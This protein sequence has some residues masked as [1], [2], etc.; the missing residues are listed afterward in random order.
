MCS[1][2]RSIRN[3]LV[4]LTPLVFILAGCEG[5][6]TPVSEDGGETNSSEIDAESGG[7]GDTSASPANNQPQAAPLA[8]GDYVYDANPAIQKEEKDWIQGFRAKLNKPIQAPPV[9]GLTGAQGYYAGENGQ[10]TG[11]DFSYTPI[12]QADLE[13]VAKIES[14]ER[15]ILA[16]TMINDD[17][18]AVLKNMP[19]LKRLNI[20]YTSISD[21]GVV[22]LK[23]LKGLTELRLDEQNF[24]EEG[25]QTLRD[26]LPNCTID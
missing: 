26:A 3:A 15:L 5:M 10:I 2:G 17:G 24:S 22:H 12:T 16:G 14:V 11:V 18:L 25:L 7:H 8:I 1:L 6:V 23:E 9:S 20:W 13:R 4:V 21:A 19:N